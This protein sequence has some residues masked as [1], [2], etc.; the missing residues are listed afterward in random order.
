MKTRR[1]HTTGEEMHPHH[2]PSVTEEANGH[3]ELGTLDTRKLIKGDDGAND[4]RGD[5]DTT[6]RYHL[7]LHGHGLDEVGALCEAIPSE[8]CL[9]RHRVG[10]RRHNSRHEL[11]AEMECVWARE[12]R[13]G[14]EVSSLSWWYSARATSDSVADDTSRM[15]STPTTCRSL[16]SAAV[17]ASGFS[18][19]LPVSSA[20]AAVHQLPR[21]CVPVHTQTNKRTLLINPEWIV[22]EGTESRSKANSTPIL[23]LVLTPAA[24]KQFSRG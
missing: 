21:R 6:K 16:P 20:T 15:A 22:R 9:R 10:Q 8:T 2:G 3:G 14:N 13:E 18:V 4:G 12:K 19:S 23:D 24:P 5:I 17:F 1:H 11:I 7:D